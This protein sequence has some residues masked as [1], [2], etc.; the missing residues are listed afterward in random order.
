MLIFEDGTDIVIS[1]IRGCGYFFLRKKKNIF[2]NLKSASS[3]NRRK[4]ERCHFIAMTKMNLY[5]SEMASKAAPLHRHTISINEIYSNDFCSRLK[6]FNFWKKL[7]TCNNLFIRNE[8]QT[9]KMYKKKMIKS[10]PLPLTQ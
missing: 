6:Q 9:L 7:K 10:C 2:V 1:D 4:A 3:E 8:K 5:L